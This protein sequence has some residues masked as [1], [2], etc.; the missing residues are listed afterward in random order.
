MKT[1]AFCLNLFYS[2]AAISLSLG[3]PQQGAYR[4]DIKQILD[5][6]DSTGNGRGLLVDEQLCN[7]PVVSDCDVSARTGLIG[8]NRIHGPPAGL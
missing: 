3:V 8:G 2:A 5:E 6:S 1:Y 4:Y 7:G